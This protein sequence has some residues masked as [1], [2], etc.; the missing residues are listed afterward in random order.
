MQRCLSS[1]FFGVMISSKCSAFLSFQYDSGGPLFFQN[2]GL[3]YL[4]RLDS[5]G[6]ACGIIVQALQQE[7]HLLFL[8]FNKI[9]DNNGHDQYIF[10]VKIK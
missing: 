6:T 9:W 5:F 3:L 2:Y 7:E 1:K 4:A 8:G 10:Y